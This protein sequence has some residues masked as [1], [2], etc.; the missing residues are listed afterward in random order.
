[1]QRYPLS[2]SEYGIFAQQISSFDTAY[3][4]PFK[5]SMGSDTDVERLRGAVIA[6]VNAHPYLKTAFSIDHKGEP[7][8]YIRDCDVKVTV[9][10]SD[11][12]GSIPIR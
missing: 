1:M 8:K 4:L 5:I 10:E 2:K 9:L 11:E 3:N 7:Y 6:A 12:L